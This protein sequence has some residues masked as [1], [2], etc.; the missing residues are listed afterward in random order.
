MYI[1]F[2]TLSSG[3]HHEL[4]RVV[5]NA[6]YVLSNMIFQVVAF[7][8]DSFILMIVITVVGCAVDYMGDAD[9]GKSLS[10]FGHKIST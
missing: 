3:L 1:Q 10:I 5:E 9:V 8:D 4:N 7:V 6:G 2:A